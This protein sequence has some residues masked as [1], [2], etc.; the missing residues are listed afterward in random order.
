MAELLGFVKVT[1]DILAFQACGSGIASSHWW[2]SSR[3][4]SPTILVR[5]INGSAEVWHCTQR[6]AVI[7][8]T[9]PR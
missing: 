5:I 8:P 9:G 6:H 3:D 2:E 1:C 7:F 4:F